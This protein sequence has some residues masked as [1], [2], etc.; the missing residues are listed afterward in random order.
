[1]LVDR[2]VTLLSKRDD[3]LAGIVGILGILRR[4]GQLALVDLALVVVLGRYHDL[5]A[6]AALTRLG[7]HG[8][9]CF[10]LGR[11]RPVVCVLDRKLVRHVV[12]CGESYQAVFDAVYDE[13]GA[14]VGRLAYRERVLGCNGMFVGAGIGNHGYLALACGAVVLDGRKRHADLL[15]R[16]A[17]RRLDDEPARIFLHCPRSGGIDGKRLGLVF[18][19][20]V[21][22]SI[23]AL[24]P[25]DFYLRRLRSRRHH[26]V[27]LLT[28]G[29]Y[30]TGHKGGRP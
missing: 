20:I 9:P 22:E 19:V 21:S 25:Y 2:K 11:E 10:V 8:I 17:A 6:L 4:E 3:R 7:C 26:R 14:A 29:K 12:A 23:T 5:N 15:A 13:L 27:I 24:C 1:M 30:R 18:A 28:A 16:L